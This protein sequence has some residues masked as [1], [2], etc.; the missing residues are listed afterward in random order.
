MPGGF[1]NKYTPTD[2]EDQEARSNND[3]LRRQSLASMAARRKV[4]MTRSASSSGEEGSRRGCLASMRDFIMRRRESKA[5]G[6]A[7]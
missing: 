3:K 1:A 2:I 4:N 6:V 7:K 5:L